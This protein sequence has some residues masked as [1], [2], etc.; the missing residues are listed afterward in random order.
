MCS[1]PYTLF[2]GAF[3]I[4]YAEITIWASQIE[5]TEKGILQQELE[6]LRKRK[7]ELADNE[8][9]ILSEKAE[10]EELNRRREE[11]LKELEALRKRSEEIERAQAK[12]KRSE[13]E[14]L[15]A[16][17]EKERARLR[18]EEVRAVIFYA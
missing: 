1:F 11:E 7:E 8:R 18:A 13:E 12:A 6:E 16:K 9:R 2:I 3:S 5:G 4:Q 17:E 15:R 14:A 10:L